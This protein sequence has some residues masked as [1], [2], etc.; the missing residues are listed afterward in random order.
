MA[1]GQSW[2]GQSRGGAL[3]HRIFLML[4]RWC[5]VRAAYVLLCLVVPYFCLFAPGASR[6]ARRFASRHLGYGWLTAWGY[7]LLNFYRLGQVLVDKAAL[8][9]GRGKRFRFSYDTSY[10][11]LLAMLERREGVVFIGA[12]VG[13]WEIGAPHFGAYAAHMHL[14]LFDG[15][16][17]QIKRLMASY[18]KAP[19]YHMIPVKAGELG[20]VVAIHNALRAGEIVCFQGDRYVEGMRCIRLPFLRGVA[21]FPAGPFATA[22]REKKAAVFYYA[23]RGRGYHYRFVFR[24]V[25]SDRVH[26]LG[27]QGLAQHYVNELER[28]VRMHPTQ[29]FNLYDFWREA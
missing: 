24:V 13:N 25:E 29:W 28:V 8:L 7:T 10:P 4:I 21:N 19:E 1:D 11:Q 18:R 17:A 3:G 27:E 23:L 2:R 14:V 20:H 12:H 5:G 9:M 16:H 15:E 6:Q 26:E 22:V